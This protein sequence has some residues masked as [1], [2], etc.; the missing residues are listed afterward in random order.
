MRVN[1]QEADRLISL[2]RARE[3]SPPAPRGLGDPARRM[4]L[5]YVEDNLSNLRLIEQLVERRPGIELLTAMQGGL[6]IEL[7]RFH[8]PG[9]ILLDLHLPDMHGAD[10][11]DTLRSDPSTRAIPV[12]V[13]SADAT[14]G[15]LERMLESGARDYLTK[16]LD[17]Q[18]ILDLLD[19]AMAQKQESS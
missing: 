13:L 3:G 8:H 4:K 9:L 16:P 1:G 19:G 7:A 12:V 15:Q 10:V 2:D 5:L 17:L 11:L 14:S 18:R 6:G